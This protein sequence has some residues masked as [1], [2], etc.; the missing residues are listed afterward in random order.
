MENKKN[1]IGVRETTPEMV[2][3]EE[4]E[5]GG[6]THQE[7]TEYFDSDTDTD[8]DFDYWEAVEEEE[9]DIIREEG[10]IKGGGYNKEKAPVDDVCPICFDRFSIPCRS[11]CGHWFCANCI[12]QFWMF[13][14]SVQPCKCPLCCCRIVNL[15]PETS[16]NHITI[17]AD[18]NVAEVLKK[19]DRYN[20]LYINGVVGA[21]HIIVAMPLFMGRILR[22]L[23]D[24]DGLRCIYYV[25]RLLGLCLALLYEKGE[26]EF[27]PTGGF[28]IQRAFDVG[29]SILIL[30]LFFVGIGYRWVLR[31]RVR[32]LAALQAS[33]S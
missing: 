17:P 32:R 9:E 22:I 11:N 33:D 10:I 28:G 18:N 7:L 20:G 3:K 23:M 12:L 26:F 14:S 2:V 4:E 16:R 13:R 15:K 29:A 5:S 8:S 30:C 25:M 27:I 19:V 6:G 24:P 21:F 31:G 1:N